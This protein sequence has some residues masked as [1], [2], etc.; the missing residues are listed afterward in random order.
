MPRSRQQ[1]RKAVAGM[2]PGHRGRARRK[3]E[4]HDTS[5]KKDRWTG[6]KIMHWCAT[7]RRHHAR[8]ERGNHG[9]TPL[10]ARASDNYHGALARARQAYTP[11]QGGQTEKRPCV[12]PESA[13]V[14]HRLPVEQS[15][16]LTNK[17]KCN[18]TTTRRSIRSACVFPCVCVCV[19]VLHLIHSHKSKPYR[20]GHAQRRPY[21]ASAA[22]ADRSITLSATSATR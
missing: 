4:R 21:C 12:T 7:C 10:S 3:R 9:G 17:K 19:R 18:A 16:C 14:N 1:R 13:G 8:A 5:T 2:R 20:E 6:R 11:L 22:L 15:T